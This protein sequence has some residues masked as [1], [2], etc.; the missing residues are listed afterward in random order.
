M[1]KRHVRIKKSELSVHLN[2]FL[3]VLYSGVFVPQIRYNNRSFHG[4][5]G[6]E[7]VVLWML[8]ITLHICSDI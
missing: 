1:I 5:F 7:S 6:M 8:W 2:I 4:V 3:H